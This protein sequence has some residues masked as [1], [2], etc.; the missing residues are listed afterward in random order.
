MKKRILVL[1]S[2]IFSIS[3]VTFAQT[4]TVTNTDLETFRQK[5]LAA[6]KDYRENYARLGFPSP[7]ELE[8]QIVEDKEKLADL[9]GRLRAQRLER[10]RTNAL[11]AQN[12]LLEDQNYLL[13]TQTNPRA[14]R[15]YFY[16]YTPF[17]Y[18][19]Y[20]Y[21]NLPRYRSNYRRQRNRRA[22]RMPPIRPPK[23]IR[24]PRIF[25]SPRNFR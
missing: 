22:N 21:Y 2:L 15:N 4:K 7:Q 19:P 20:G 14:E 1:L 23:P 6:E 9:S 18:L 8:K 3:A 17:V 25:R 11:D 13:Q 5:R 16:G 24:P 10:E 12:N